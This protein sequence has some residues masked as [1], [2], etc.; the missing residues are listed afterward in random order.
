[1]VKLK[2]DILGIIIISI[3]VLIGPFPRLEAVTTLAPQGPYPVGLKVKHVNFNARD[4]RIL[5]WYPAQEVSGSEG[6]KFERGLKGSA[7]LDAEPDRSGAPYPLLLFSHGLGGRADQSVYYCQNLASFGYVVVSPDHADAD[8]VLKNLSI[9]NIF[10]FLRKIPH[11]QKEAFGM[12]FVI[13]T[14]NDYFQK[15]N[16]DLSYRPEEASFTIDQAI[17]WNRD[18]S[19]MLYGMM[20]PDLIGATGHSLGGLTT[21]AIGGL[22]IKCD[23]PEDLDTSECDL[24]DIDPLDMSFVCCIEFAR[25]CEP[26]EYSDERVKAIIPLGPAIF[27]PHLERVAAGLRVPLMIITGESVRLEAPWPPMKTVYDNAPPPK[28]LIRVRKTDHMTIADET[29]SISWLVRPVLPGFRFH[30]RDKAQVYMDYS[31]AFFD[32]YIKGDESRA[33]FLKEPSSRFLE[34][35][36]E[37]E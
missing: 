16:F 37:P 34:L 10:K 25:E 1:M 31:V 2:R 19:H 20:D 8:I 30:Y 22:P 11:V 17:E 7:V 6:Y 36:S 12:A 33:E 29:L 27:F 18:S 5:V 14:F 3:P 35:W 13:T 21:L 28:Y 26:F 23:E 32:L 24:T 4:M 9:K 15:I